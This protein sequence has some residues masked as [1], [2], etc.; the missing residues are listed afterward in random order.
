MRYKGKVYDRK[1][2]PLAGIAVSDGRNVRYTDVAGHFELPGYERTRLI[3]V[4][5]LTR[6]HSDWYIHTAGHV[7]DYNF[8]I[9]LAET[10]SD[11]CFLQTSDTE[12]LG[13][14][15]EDWLPFVREQV[16]RHQPAFLVHTG[17]ICYE[18]GLKKHYLEMNE[19]TTG[20]PV[21]YVIGNHDYV[22]GAYG[23]EFYEK[24]YGPV[25]YSFDCGEIHFVALAIGEGDRPSGYEQ[26]D[27]LKW[28]LNDLEHVDKGKKLIVLEHTH[29]EDVTGFRKTVGSMTID[30]KKFGLLAW[31][32]GH[33]HANLL[34]EYDGIYNIGT[35][36]PDSGGIDSSAGGLRK[37]ALNGYKL[38]SQMLYFMLP[39]KTS[40]PYAWRIKLPGRVFFSTPIMAEGDVIVC[41]AEDGYPCRCGIYRICGETGSIKWSYPTESGIKND[42]ALDGGNVYAQDIKGWL[43]C[44]DAKEGTL[45]WK[46]RSALYGAG[47][48]LTGV[49]IVDN[50]VF[51]GSMQQVHAF[52]KRN[53][54][55]CWKSQ[56]CEWFT[57]SPTRFVYDEKNGQLIVGLQWEKLYALDVKTGEILWENKS[58]VRF[59][60]ATPLVKGDKIYTVTYNSAVILQAATGETILEK[61]MGSSM[62]V[63]GKPVLEDDILYYPTAGRG[64]LA[65]DADTL[66][67]L[68]Q[69]PAAPAAIFTP[70]YNHGNIQTVESTPQISGRK[71]VFAGSD[72]CVRFYDKGTAE[73][74]QCIHVG[75]P[76]TATPILGDGYVIT[77]DFTGNVTKYKM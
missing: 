49:L 64:V 67:V 60:T 58:D 23:E 39:V 63:S 11:F 19:A 32:F 17:D 38:T 2:V 66:E 18:E 24:L 25:W 29:C 10:V 28:L 76:C 68:R 20:C 48:T 3:Y 27:Q 71:L 36:R 5:A 59:R 70:P 73:L 52:D 21:R 75:A 77:A 61:D 37:I 47:Y 13:R 16:V 54:F 12:L 42:I 34:L 31:V 40:D 43:Y 8:Q 30:F 72:G 57:C 7:G 1:H 35:S 62:E 15:C 56:K 6:G 9:E 50:T 51:A 55:L 46:V 33:Y 45:N 26:E 53:G 69:Y 22:D 65:L 44:I 74:V 4:C 41:T 14:G